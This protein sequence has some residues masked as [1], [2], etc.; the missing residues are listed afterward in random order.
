MFVGLAVAVG[1]LSALLTA[2]VEMLVVKVGS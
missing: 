1:V 2:V